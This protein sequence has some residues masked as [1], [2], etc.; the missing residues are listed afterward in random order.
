MPSSRTAKTCCA[1]FRSMVE[2]IV[3][4]MGPDVDGRNERAFKKVGV[5][6]YVDVCGLKQ[7]C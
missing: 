3:V 5:L 1:P 4:E 2:G 7:S 6:L